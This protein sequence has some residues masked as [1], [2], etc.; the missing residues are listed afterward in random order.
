M[1]KQERTALKLKIL[2]AANLNKENYKIAVEPCG[3][4]ADA[5]YLPDKFDGYDGLVLCGGNDIN[6]DIYGQE[7]NGSVEIDYERDKAEIA[8][9]EY[10]LKEGKPILGICRGCQLLNAYFGGT[11]IQDI[12]E[13]VPVHRNVEVDRIHGVKTA[14][15]GIM[16]QLYGQS[17]TVNSCHHQALDKI[18]DGFRVTLVSDDGIVEAI[19]HET[20]PIFAVQ[21]HPE[22][23]CLEKKNADTVDGIK[24]FERFVEMCEEQA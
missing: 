22:R 13:K 7:I 18:A 10:F 6:P 21:W 14:G 4:E 2:L 15:D 23:I 1:K 24:I 9:L 8:A 12:G 20:L 17:F 3:V 19:E 16:K 5:V 11:L